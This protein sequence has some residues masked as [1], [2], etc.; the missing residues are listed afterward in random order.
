LDELNLDWGL[1]AQKAKTKKFGALPPE[2]PKDKAKQIRYL[3]TKGFS[4]SHI[5]AIFDGDE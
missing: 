5:R 4:G 3:Q 2:S 1:A